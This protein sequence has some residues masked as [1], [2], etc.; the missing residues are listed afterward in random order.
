MDQT[1][2]LVD[3]ANDF[4]DSIIQ[5]DWVGWEWGCGGSSVWLGRRLAHLTSFEHQIDWFRDVKER[6][7]RFGIDNVKLYHCGKGTAYYVEY[8]DAILQQQD[9]SLDLILV[10]GRARP[11]C[12]SNAITKLKR[13]GVLILDDSQRDYYAGG[14]SKVPAHW[15]RHDFEGE[16]NGR[17]V[18]TVWRRPL[19][20][21][22]VE[23]PRR[24]V[25]WLCTADDN[26][27]YVREAH[28]S[29]QSVIDNIPGVYTV[30]FLKGDTE[31][32]GWD[33]I[34]PLPDVVPHDFWYL[35]SLRWMVWAVV[36]L[37][38]QGWE[39]CLYLD[40]DTYVA[41]RA[42]NIFDVL[43]KF[44]FAIP[45]SPQRDCCNSALLPEPPE[46][47]CT[48]EN[49][50]TLFRNNEKVR[51]F[52]R[53]W[54]ERF[55]ATPKIYDDNDCAPLRDELWENPEGV[56]WVA[57]APEFGLRFDFGAWVTGRVRILHGRHHGI[58]TDVNLLRDV[59]AAINEWVSMRIWMDGKLASKPHDWGWYP[60]SPGVVTE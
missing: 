45:Q 23:R 57:L 40:T 38:K 44:E 4:L 22:P 12:M 26:G 27:R 19:D 9:E 47:F 14:I 28:H 15:E 58:S 11:R 60:E 5:P 59:A 43:R 30:L 3:A 32:R 50:V 39:E 6:L 52:W 17:K 54:L 7:G 24:V 46:S 29:L 13:G 25:F 1:P 21:A 8:A 33:E 35:V 10:D 42:T 2:W 49:G 48:L 34:V 37:G 51:R 55:E 36:W 41:S 20:D 18:T 16:W 56:K 53:N 31:L